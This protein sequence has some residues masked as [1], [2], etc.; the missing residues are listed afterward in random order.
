MEIYHYCSDDC[1]NPYLLDIHITIFVD[2]VMYQERVERRRCKFR[3]N[4]NGHELILVK[5]W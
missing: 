4:Q 1:K 2:E 3:R 5:K